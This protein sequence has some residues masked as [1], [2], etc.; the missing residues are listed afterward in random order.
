MLAVLKPIWSI[1]NGS[2]VPTTQCAV[3]VLVSQ[4][5]TTQTGMEEINN[6]SGF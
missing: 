6:E 3:T 1:M 4:N 5:Y 2:A